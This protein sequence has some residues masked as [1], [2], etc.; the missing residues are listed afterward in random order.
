MV[1]SAA[2]T[3]LDSRRCRLARGVLRPG[4]TPLA[5]GFAAEARTMG[6]I[7]GSPNNVEAVTAYFEKREPKFEDVS[8]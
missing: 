8:E 5:D 1:P 6:S 4:T 3:S 7:I 2:G